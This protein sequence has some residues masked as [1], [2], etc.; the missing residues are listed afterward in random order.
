MEKKKVKL[1][2][3]PLKVNQEKHGFSGS[4]LHKGKKTS[5]I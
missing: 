2:Y 4:G 1:D 5:T 3:F